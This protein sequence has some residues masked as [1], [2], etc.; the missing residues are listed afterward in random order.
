MPEGTDV[1]EAG[2]ILGLVWHEPGEGTQR[3]LRGQEVWGEGAWTGRSGGA[4]W[5]TTWGPLKG[6]QVQRQ[7][8]RTVSEAPAPQGFSGDGGGGRGQGLLEKYWPGSHSEV[9]S[10]G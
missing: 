7:G 9:I 10:Q 4:M 3:G 8:Y 1:C 2:E 5:G 6:P